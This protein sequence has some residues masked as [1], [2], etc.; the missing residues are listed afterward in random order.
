MKQDGADFAVGQIAIAVFNNN[1][2]LN[3]MGDNYLQKQ[4]S[5]RTNI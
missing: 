4:M 2:G 3:P 5:Q 1:R